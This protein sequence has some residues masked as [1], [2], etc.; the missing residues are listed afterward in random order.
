MSNFNTNKVN[1][2]EIK[3]V[4]S[5]ISTTRKNVILAPKMGLTNKIAPLKTNQFKMMPQ[6]SGF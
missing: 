4:T 2:K 1:D 3:N 5:D 6:N